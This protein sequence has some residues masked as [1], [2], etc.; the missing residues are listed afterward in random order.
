M[1]V[2]IR[3]FGLIRNLAQVEQT[4]VETDEHATIAVLL[5]VLAREFPELPL[6][7]EHISFLVNGKIVNRTQALNPDDEITIFE[8]FAGG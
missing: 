1:R 5:T 4:T 2:R 3:F 8:M 6:E 7:Q